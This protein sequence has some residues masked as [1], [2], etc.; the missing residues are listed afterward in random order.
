MTSIEEL[1][2]IRL[3]KR[4]KAIDSLAYALEIKGWKYELNGHYEK[5]K[6][7]D[8]SDT[9]DFKE[10]CIEFDFFD[11]YAKVTIKGYCPYE[12]ISSVAKGRIL[13][14]TTLFN[15]ELKL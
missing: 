3:K 11:E 4:D 8:L 12:C 1:R 7:N 6:D 14:H 5:Y 15:M 10:D 2:K 9:I 13:M